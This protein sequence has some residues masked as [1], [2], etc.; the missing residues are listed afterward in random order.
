MNVLVTGA[1][2]FIGSHIIEELFSGGHKITALAHYNSRNSYGNLELL[3]KKIQKEIKILL[4]DICD[5]Y[6]MRKI[7]KG[8]D[9]VIHMAALIGI[10]YSYEAFESNVRT[11][12]L[13]TN[14]LVHE[15]MYSGVTRFIH[16]STSEV[17]GTGQ[18]FPMDEKHPL[19]AQSP[20]SAT[21]IGADKIVESVYNSYNFPTVTL[22]PFNN[23][24][25]R[26]S[27]RAIIPTIISQ[28]LAGENLNIGSIST[29]RDFCYVKDTAR[30][31]ASAL[32]AK[33]VVGQ[34]IN[35]GTGRGHSIKEVIAKVQNITG[36]KIKIKVDKNRIRA[37][38]SEVEKLIGDRKK[39]KKLL[40]WEPKYSL[41]KGLE[42]T[43][44][45]IKN[46]R[47]L[48]KENTYVI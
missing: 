4:G 7:L 42:E 21:K 10:P 45:W 6:F 26:Q 33:N 13:G 18:Y 47:N 17:Y 11:N 23:F 30:A 1:G 34:T 27:A 41:D 35:L 24:G 14:I 39:A 15:S 37:K 8:K 44:N 43:I 22:R 9:A 31:Y 16:T 38:K 3:D 25:P 32:K 40:L 12:I 5:H 36:K 28:V 29:I 20:Y 2:G 48:F 19:N 46:N